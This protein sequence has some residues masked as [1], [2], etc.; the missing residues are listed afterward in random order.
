MFICFGARLY[1]FSVS[2]SHVLSGGT[3]CIVLALT[4][5]FAVSNSD[6]ISLALLLFRGFYYVRIVFLWC[7]R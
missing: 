2:A 4:S 7:C 6:P 5:P 3:I 1:T